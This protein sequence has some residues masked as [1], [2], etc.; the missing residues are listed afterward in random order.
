MLARVA[1]LIAGCSRNSDLAARYGGEEFLLILPESDLA[2]AH[3]L[4]DRIHRIF[5]IL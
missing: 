1:E 4:V 5:R 2:A 3:L